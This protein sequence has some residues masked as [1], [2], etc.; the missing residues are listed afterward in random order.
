MRARV[1]PTRSAL[2]C[3]SCLLPTTTSTC[4]ALSSITVKNV[5]SYCIS[6]TCLWSMAAKR[7]AFGRRLL[8]RCSLP[9]E[10]AIAIVARCFKGLL[11]LSPVT[12]TLSSCYAVSEA[13]VTSS[14]VKRLQV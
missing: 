7:C 3:G 10:G 9:A 12:N 11:L 6:D 2:P 1:W 4:K 5:A 14:S 13:V 8:I